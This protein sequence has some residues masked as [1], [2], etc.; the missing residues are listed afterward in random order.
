M[1]KFLGF[2]IWFENGKPNKM[3][4]A[5]DTKKYHC[6]GNSIEDFANFVCGQLPIIGMSA[7]IE[8]LSFDK[9]KNVYTAKLIGV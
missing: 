6:N 3:T 2:D 8:N 7:K 1:T 5:E 9:E 4:I